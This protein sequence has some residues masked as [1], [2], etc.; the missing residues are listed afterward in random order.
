MAGNTIRIGAVNYLNTK[1]LIY[2][3]EKGMMQE[4]ISLQINYPANIARALLNQE[5]DL[6]LVPVA[7]LPHL[8]TWHIISPFGIACDGPV[9]S[10]CL[11][12]DVPLDAIQT[13]LLDYQSRTSAAL[14]KILLQEYWHI[15]PVFIQAY[16][17][18]EK[19]IKGSTAGLIIGDRALQQRQHS[20]Y[21]FDLGEAWKMHTGLPFVFAAWVSNKKLNDDFIDRFNTTLQYGLNRLD[22]VVALHDSPNLNL[23]EYYQRHIRFHFSA[24]CRHG[25]QLFLDK[26]KASSASA[27]F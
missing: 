12:S 4:E 25:L 20:R 17:G 6:G 15:Q 10:V 18:Y 24:S 3:F 21:I 8:K 11:F 13:V 19:D 27:K 1:P 16:E 7:V 26:L 22:E 23:A 9:A 2:G 5:I 14:L